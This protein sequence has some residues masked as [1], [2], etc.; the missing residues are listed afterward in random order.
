M[1]YTVITG[2]EIEGPQLRLR[3]NFR[4][5][6]AKLEVCVYG[7]EDWRKDHGEAEGQGHD[8]GAVGSGTGSF[9]SCG[10]QVGDGCVS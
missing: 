9:G 4:I 3:Q 10:E 8:A 5:C 6:E 1:V 2:R 7:F